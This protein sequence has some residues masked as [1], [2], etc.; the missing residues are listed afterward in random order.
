MYI[1]IHTLYRF[2]YMY[3]KPGVV[4]LQYM[5]IGTN[6]ESG[7]GPIINYFKNSL[8]RDLKTQRVFVL[9]NPLITQ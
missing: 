1:I 3:L 8:V 7:G 9:H 2:I 5:R 6:K 4:R